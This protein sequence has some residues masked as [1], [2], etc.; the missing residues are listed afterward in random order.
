MPDISFTI[1]LK[2]MNNSKDVHFLVKSLY[3][4]LNGLNEQTWPSQS[5]TQRKS[6]E[7][8]TILPKKPIFNHVNVML[9]IEPRVTLIALAT[10][11]QVEQSYF[12][13]NK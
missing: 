9:H 7:Y 10:S 12:E 5:D 11:Y 13:V 3:L 8:Q 4:S 6:G 1:D 2:L